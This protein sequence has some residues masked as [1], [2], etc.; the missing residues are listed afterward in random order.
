MA[1]SRK[2]FA[3]PCG[4][5]PGQR[6]QIVLA[7]IM[8]NKCAN[9]PLKRPDCPFFFL[10]LI[11]V[12]SEGCRTG[13]PPPEGHSPD[14]AGSPANP[15]AFIHL[16]HRT[17]KNRLLHMFVCGSVVL[18]GLAACDDDNPAQVPCTLTLDRSQLTLAIGQTKSR[19]RNW[20]GRRTTQRSL[21]SP[22]DSWKRGLRV[23]PQ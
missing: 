2:R 8:G 6:R 5:E 7:R 4:S 22:M 14:T 10:Y 9:R 18:L 11:R 15:H 13:R 1:G 20:S 17:M 3:P 12:R 19:E 23:L 21:S 16:T